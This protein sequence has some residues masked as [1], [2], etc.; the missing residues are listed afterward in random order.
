M[1]HYICTGGCKGESEKSGVCQAEGCPKQGRPLTDCACQDG[2]HI[3]F[4]EDRQTFKENP[5]Q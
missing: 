3:N 4:K 5:K 1:I 2:K